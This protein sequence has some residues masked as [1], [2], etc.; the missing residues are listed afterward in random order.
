M[1]IYLCDFNYNLH[2]TWNNMRKGNICSSLMSFHETSRR[3]SPIWE[4]LPSNLSWSPIGSRQS[5]WL[6]NCREACKYDELEK[7][8]KCRSLRQLHSKYFPSRLIPVRW[9]PTAVSARVRSKTCRIATTTALPAW[10]WPTRRRLW[11]SLTAHNVRICQC[12]PW[13][14]R[15]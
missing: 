1:C 14:L 3:K 12:G 5:N 2:D 4:L 7:Q 10:A 8:Y 13:P 11:R 6:A 15:G 9:R